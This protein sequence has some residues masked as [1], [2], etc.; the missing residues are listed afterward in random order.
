MQYR[1]AQSTA[2]PLMFVSAIFTRRKGNPSY[3]MNHHTW[4]KPDENP[5]ISSPSFPLEKEILFEKDEK[6]Q[7]LYNCSLNYEKVC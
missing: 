1:H 6:L 4:N 5:T 3:L 7:V 2:E